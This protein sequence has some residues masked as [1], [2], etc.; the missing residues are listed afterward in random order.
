M[1]A[2]ASAGRLRFGGFNG[3]FMVLGVVVAF[4]AGITIGVIGQTVLGDDGASEG[5]ATARVIPVAYDSP[6]Q[7]EGLLSGS[8][9]VSAL[10][11]TSD[12][13]G[14]GEGILGG[15]TSQVSPTLP[16]VRDVAVGMG[17]G[18]LAYGRPAEAIY[19]EP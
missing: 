9:P 15:N 6:G 4:V 13:P 1:R 19:H 18:W 3:S 11:N 17:E 14:Q 16:V 7:G 5:A 10:L 12:N 2:M 8:V